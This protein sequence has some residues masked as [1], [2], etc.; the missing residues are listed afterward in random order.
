MN[1]ILKAT[2]I[3]FILAR[4]SFAGDIVGNGGGLAEQNISFALLNL[5]KIYSLCLSSNFCLSQKSDRDVLSKIVAHLPT[6]LKNPQP[7]IFLSGKEHPEI[8]KIN[9]QVKLAVTG[10]H[11]GDPIYLNTDLIY[12]EDQYGQIAPMSI[13][14]AMGILTHE[15]GHHHEIKNHDYLDLLGSRVH[16]FALQAVNTLAVDTYLDIG[17]E[18]PPKL[19]LTAI[20]SRMQSGSDLQGAESLLLFAD[21]SEV[22]DLSSELNSALQFCPATSQY[23]KR[24]TLGYRLFDIRWDGGP[25]RGRSFEKRTYFVKARVEL[26]CE[27]LED[28]NYPVRFDVGHELK[29]RLPVSF[30]W[31]PNGEGSQF[32]WQLQKSQIQTELSPMR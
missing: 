6:E 23:K 16:T 22:H 19:V 17:D 28:Y 27:H 5:P 15:L 18:R 13:P 3:F 4:T 11:V 29:L 31:V 26:F 25:V 1:P 12:Q 20:H 30:N 21:E 32:S 8:F 9:N 2:V 14:A 7:L 24:R 10:N